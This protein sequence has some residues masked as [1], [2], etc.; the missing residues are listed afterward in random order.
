M[1]FKVVG[2][3][4]NGLTF[5]RSI[6]GNTLFF[7]EFVDS[8]DEKIGF[9]VYG[10]KSKNKVSVFE[11]GTLYLNSS[12]ILEISRTRRLENQNYSYT[13]ISFSCIVY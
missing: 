3:D 13:L 12:T 9:D 7:I 4:F 8:N 11:K 6:I 5:K 2:Q 10:G 1:D